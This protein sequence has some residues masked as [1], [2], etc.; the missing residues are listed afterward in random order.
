METGFLWPPDLTRNHHPQ[1]FE[2]MKVKDVLAW[3]SEK[4]THVVTWS[5]EKATHV[6]T[7]SS[8]HVSDALCVSINVSCRKK[9]ELFD[10]PGGVVFFCILAFSNVF[11]L[12]VLISVVGGFVTRLL[13]PAA[14]F[15]RTLRDPRAHAFANMQREVLGKTSLTVLVP[16]YLPNEQLI[17]KSTIAHL[18]H[19]LEYGFPFRLIVCYNTPYPIAFEDELRELDG[20]VYANGRSVQILKVEGSSSKAENLNCALLS[21]DTEYVALY[22]ADHHP[23]AHSLLIASAHM[24]ARGVACVQGSTYLRSLPNFMAVYINAEFFVTHFVFFPAMQFLTSFGIFGG[25]NALWRTAILK[26]YQF[27]HDVQ[28]EDIDVSIRSS[29][30]GRVKISFC[31]ECRSGELPPRTFNDLYRQRLRWALGWDQVT[32]QHMRSIGSS[33]ELNC[34]EKAG[35]Y[36]LLPLRWALLLSGVANAL[37]AP[38]VASAWANGVGGELGGP[39][40]TCYAF[41][42][43]TYAT[44]FAVAAINAILHEPRQRWPAIIAFQLTGAVYI[45][46]NLALYFISLIKICTGADS[47]W[48]VTTRAPDVPSRA[49]TAGLAYLHPSDTCASSPRPELSTPMQAAF[50]M[51]CEKELV[52]KYN[53]ARGEVSDPPIPML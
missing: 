25:S 38:I 53:A 13:D 47:E 34:A 41:S 18:I 52:E 32:L 33:T 20:Y 28:T 22:D 9:P 8:Q 42:F 30:D 11:A 43:T 2:N 24:A 4:A 10:Q 27:R 31:P 15:A 48:V 45:G 5:S 36:Y 21:V 49:R 40:E 12:L 6:V 19:N 3:S 44:L 51:S 14:A 7:W 29:L 35:M 17:V 37:V 16:C 39:I 23:D 46:W 1:G 50:A 26:A